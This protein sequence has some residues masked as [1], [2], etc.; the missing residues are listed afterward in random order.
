MLSTILSDPFAPA[1]PATLLAA[2]KALQ[3]VLQTCWPRIPNSPWQ[4]EIINA[5]TLC[6]LAACDQTTRPSAIL[7][8]L[9][10]TGAMLSAV[11]RTKGVNL[12][13]V[14]APLVQKEPPL[15]ALFASSPSS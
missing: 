13:D 15:A 12:A 9:S 14:V 11:L 2:V 6:W 3:A 10:A 8:E 4:D 5:L 7:S 1:A